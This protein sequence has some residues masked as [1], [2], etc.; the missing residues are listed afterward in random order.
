[1]GE[2]IPRSVEGR[3][4]EVRKQTTNVGVV[5]YVEDAFPL[6][7][8]PP[9]GGVLSAAASSHLSELECRFTMDR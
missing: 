6:E 2:Y 8:P 1:M 9:R 3:V 7:C 5:G 4:V